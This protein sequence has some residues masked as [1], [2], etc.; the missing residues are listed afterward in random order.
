VFLPNARWPDG[1]VRAEHAWVDDFVETCA[2]FPKGAHDDD[3]DALSQLLLRCQ[4][5]GGL[6]AREVLA[7][8]V[9]RDD[10]EEESES[11]GLGYRGYKPFKG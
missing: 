4:S 6:T 2:M 10:D 5:H 9:D 8:K 7:I 11:H 3:V 1:S